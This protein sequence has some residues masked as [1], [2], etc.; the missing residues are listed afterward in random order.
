M[1]HF[2][3][4]MWTQYPVLLTVCLPHWTR[5]HFKMPLGDARKG[6]EKK[7]EGGP[8]AKCCDSTWN[9]ICAGQS[10]T[11]R[12]WEQAQIIAVESIWC[13]W[14]KVA[15]GWLKRCGKKAAKWFVQFE[16]RIQMRNEKCECE[17]RMASGK[18][19]CQCNELETE[20]DID[21]SR[22]NH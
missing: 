22:R 10:W 12:I 17:M 16:L 14:G 6:R 2:T 9:A 7:G 15:L 21:S 20:T 19:Q 3:L 5:L 13:N 8:V 4:A 11:E 1:T 18:C